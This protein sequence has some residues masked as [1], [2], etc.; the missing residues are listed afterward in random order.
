MNMELETT[1]DL[2]VRGEFSAAE[3]HAP[4]SVKKFKVWL[5]RND[6][7]EGRRM[8]RGIDITD[9][10]PDS[11]HQDLYNQLLDEMEARHDQSRDP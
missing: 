10:L 4:A 7:I 2:E 3:P 11:V 9:F 1:L 5:G 8:Y 6:F